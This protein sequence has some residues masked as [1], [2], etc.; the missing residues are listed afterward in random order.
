MA[1]WAALLSD[2]EEEFLSCCF[3]TTCWPSE[4]SASRKESS[5]FFARSDIPLPPFFGRE[6]ETGV[7]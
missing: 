2:F 1:S 6:M 7:E 4:A 3:R 5:V